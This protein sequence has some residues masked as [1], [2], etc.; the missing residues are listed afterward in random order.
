EGALRLTLEVD[1]DEVLAR[2]E[3]LAEVVVAVAPDAERVERNGAEVA[4]EGDGLGLAPDE[5]LAVAARVLG[6]LVD[7]LAQ[8]LHGPAHRVAH[9]LNEGALV[10]LGVLL[11]SE[12][13]IAVIR[14]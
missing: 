11:G 9:G 6:E 2:P 1:D 3:D 10:Q 7:L 13:G 5:L 8:Q 4:G 14:G 12:R